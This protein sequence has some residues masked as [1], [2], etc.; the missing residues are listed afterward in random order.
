MPFQYALDHPI[1][2]P[3]L[4]H[5][6]GRRGQTPAEHALAPA[7]LHQLLWSQQLLGSAPYSAGPPA[8]SFTE[9]RIEDLEYLLE[10]GYFAPLG[11]RRLPRRRL[12]R[13]GRAGVVGAH[14]RP[15]EH[16]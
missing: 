14:R 10:R 3:A 9:S 11:R 5:F 6:T 4:T 8:V 2:A 7:R 12:H 16:P 15:A 1:A 13:G